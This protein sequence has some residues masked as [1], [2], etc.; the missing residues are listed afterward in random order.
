V[1]DSVR[2][3]AALVCPT[4]RA[5]VPS[6]AQISTSST[7]EA[8][9]VAFQRRVAFVVGCVVLLGVSSAMTGACLSSVRVCVLVTMGG[10]APKCGSKMMLARLAMT[11]P[12]SAS[13]RGRMR[14]RTAPSP[15]G[16]F[17]FGGRKPSW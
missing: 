4:R 13:L 3:P 16:G 6:C 8:S 9:S 2:S 7:P 17:V 15:C 10:F 5:F 14:K 11:V 1:P 12:D